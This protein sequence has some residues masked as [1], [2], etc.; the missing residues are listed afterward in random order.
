MDKPLQISV[1]EVMTLHYGRSLLRGERLRDSPT[2]FTRAMSADRDSPVPARM[3]S[4]KTQMYTSLAR[5]FKIALE[6]M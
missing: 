4:F 1:V 2:S 3:P 6:A 5:L